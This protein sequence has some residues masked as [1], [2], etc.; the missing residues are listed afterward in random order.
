M[1][2]FQ[3]FVFL[4][5]AS[6]RSL[7]T[8]DL[9]GEQDLAAADGMNRFAAFL[10]LCQIDLGDFLELTPDARVEK[11]GAFVGAE[12]MVRSLFYSIVLK[13]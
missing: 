3:K 11:F 5:F 12:R 10:I 7:L 8:L 2:M 13:F 6:S 1:T 9:K 4:D